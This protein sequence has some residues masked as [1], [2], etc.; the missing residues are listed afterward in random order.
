MAGVG[1]LLFGG[2][3]GSR[4]NLDPSSFT[5]RL[6]GIGA[7][8][9]TAHLLAWLYHISP[10]RGLNEMFGVLAVMSTPGIIEVVRVALALAALWALARGRRQ[11]ALILGLGCLVVS[12]TIG[13]SAAINPLFAIPAKI[14]HLLAASVWMGGLLWLGWT[15]R[16]DLTAFRIEA[17]RVSFAALI[18]VI[19]VATTGVIQSVLFMHWPQDLVRTDYGRLV[20]AKIGG[21]ILLISLGAYNRYR[22]VPHIDDSRKAARLSRSV[23]QELVLMVVILIISGFL[24]NVP[25]PTTLLP[26]FTGAAAQ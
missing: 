20:L 19:A 13:H 7:V 12:G 6:L 1:L 21:L 5:T 4:R 23:A 9:L 22:L 11:P 8:I 16:R 3:A 2:A 24:A 10:G 18:S 14:I 15:F 26:A 25:A 17:R